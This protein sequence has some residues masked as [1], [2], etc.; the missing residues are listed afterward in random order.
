[1]SDSGTF[2]SLWV[3]DTTCDLGPIEELAES[4][5]SVIQE[6]EFLQIVQLGTIHKKGLVAFS[7]A[8]LQRF[9]SLMESSFDS[10]LLAEPICKPVKQALERIASISRSFL[11]FFCEEGPEGCKPLG[12]YDVLWW[13]SYSANQYPEKTLQKLFVEKGSFWERETQEMIEKGGSAVLLNEKVGELQVLLQAD[14]K[15]T[16]EKALRTMTQHYIEISKSMRSQKLCKIRE[17]FLDSW[18]EFRTV[19]I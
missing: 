11:Q 10:A 14:P 16:D 8:F 9:Q 13:K 12:D 15:T 17:L 7:F 18:F 3:C 19:Q 5:L 6:N 1:M 4:M 2:D